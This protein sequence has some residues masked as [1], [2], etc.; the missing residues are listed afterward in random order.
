L[1]PPSDKAEKLSLS[2]ANGTVKETDPLRLLRLYPEKPVQ[3]G[4]PMGSFNVNGSFMFPES[5]NNTAMVL[6][7]LEWVQLDRENYN[8]MMYGIEGEDYVLKDGKPEKP[9]GM[10]SVAS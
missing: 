8:L 3:R 7:F 5:S 10:V 6:R 1:T 2:T 9:E 4:N